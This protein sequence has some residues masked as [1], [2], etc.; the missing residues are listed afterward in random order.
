MPSIPTSTPS[1]SNPPPEGLGDRISRLRRKKKL[2]QGD[3]AERI[4]T[5]NHQLSKYERGIHE[6]SLELLSRIA[7]TLDTSTDF[8]ITGKEPASRDQPFGLESLSPELRE[9][10]TEFLGSVMKADT[11]IRLGRNARKK[12]SD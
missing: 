10:L 11:V 9:P 5:S 1:S 7:R 2:S 12:P 3:L 4:G 6:P 8:L